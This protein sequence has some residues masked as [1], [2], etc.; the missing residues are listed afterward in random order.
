MS[1]TYGM[2]LLIELD[3]LEETIALCKALELDFIELNMNFPQY[4]LDQLKNTRYFKTLAED[5]G[6]FYTMH[7]DENLNVSD[8][9]PLVREAYLETV[10]QTIELS[11]KI[12]VKILNMHMHKGI[13]MTMPTHKVFMFEAYKAQYLESIHTFKQKCIKAIGN[14]DLKIAIE[15]TSGFADF[16]KEALE[17]LLESDVFV[18]TWDIGHSNAYAKEDEAFIQSHLDKLMHFHFHDSC[19]TQDHMVLGTGEI[20]LLEK[21]SIVRQTKSTCLIETKSV[22]ALK[23]SV[24]WLKKV[25]P[26]RF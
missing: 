5:H 26:S 23:L 2:P 13:Y 17:I 12:G 24:E 4:G 16:Q 20:D 22:E 10:M 18:L 15:N 6:I 8:F 7:L 21:L 25:L 19:G 1:V 14:S 11:K 9:N 3:H